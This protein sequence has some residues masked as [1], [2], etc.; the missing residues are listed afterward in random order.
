[1]E[2]VVR[3]TKSELCLSTLPKY[4]HL[5]IYV[6]IVCVRSQDLYSPSIDTSGFLVGF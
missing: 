3:S 4:L 6:C 1:M 5:K 2:H